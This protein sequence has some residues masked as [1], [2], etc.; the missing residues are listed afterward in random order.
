MTIA[1]LPVARGSPPITPPPAPAR[2]VS[3]GG[4]PKEPSRV[5]VEASEI[6]SVATPLKRADR[7]AIRTELLAVRSL[8]D[9]ER[10]EASGFTRHVLG[11]T[12]G[13]VRPFALLA[14]TYRWA[15]PTWSVLVKAD[16][17]VVSH[18][19]IL[20]RMVRVGDQP[21]MVA[22]VGDV[23]TQPAYRRRGYASAA[24]AKATS[25]AA[26]MLAVPFALR[27]CPA[28]TRPPSNPLAWQIVD[29]GIFC[30]QAGQMVPLAGETLMVL[31]L[32]AQ[33]WPT[34]WVDLGG[35]PW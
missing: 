24:V 28:G 32:G 16:G 3:S 29:D 2:T 19:G 1:E 11:A 14:D 6:P 34:G 18:A 33:D 20:L 26:T 7:P 27:L 12:D 22:G 30:E 13:R 9:V 5:P 23:M 15:R 10:E 25:F 17:H 8:S 35:E 21:V 4:A 31:A